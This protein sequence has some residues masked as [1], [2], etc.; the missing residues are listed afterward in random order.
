M[1]IGR[2]TAILIAKLTV[3]YYYLIF[4]GSLTAWNFNQT[5]QK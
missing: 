3:H 1:N 5:L 4:S 2:Q